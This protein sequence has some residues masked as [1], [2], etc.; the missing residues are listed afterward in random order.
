MTN[1]KE[2]NQIRETVSFKNHNINIGLDVHKKIG[3]HQFM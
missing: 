2:K 1:L 3:R